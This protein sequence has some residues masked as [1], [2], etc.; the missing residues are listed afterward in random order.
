MNLPEYKNIR[1][2]LAQNGRHEVLDILRHRFVALTPEEWVRQHFVNYLV[3]YKG[4]PVALMANE[5]E[6]TVGEKKLRCDSVMFD[7]YKRPRII[8]EYKAES[9]PITNKVLTQIATYNMLLHV[10][11]LFISNGITHLCLHYSHER[12]KWEFL[13]DIPDYKSIDAPIYSSTK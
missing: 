8:M 4:Y 12:G 5:V 7:R 9:V 10:D 13:E 3:N 6:L 2:R 1:I 11:Y